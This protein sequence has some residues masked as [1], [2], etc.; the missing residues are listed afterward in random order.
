MDV[1]GAQDNWSDEEAMFSAAT[2]TSKG[3][4]RFRCHHVKKVNIIMYKSRI[5]LLLLL[6]RVIYLAQTYRETL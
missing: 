3:I 4:S 5:F 6:E 1:S 2:E